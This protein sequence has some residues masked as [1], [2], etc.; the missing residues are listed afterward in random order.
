MLNYVKPTITD[1]GD[2]RQLTADCF[3]GTGG[4][5]KVPGGYLG[6]VPLGQ[7]TSTCQSQ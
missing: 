4:D 1:H 6:G 3:G 2:L 7:H 5:S